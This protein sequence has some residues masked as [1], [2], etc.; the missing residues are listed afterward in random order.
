MKN[1]LLCCAALLLSALTQAQDY[2]ATENISLDTQ[3]T[4]ISKSTV[5]SGIIYERVITIAN[6]YNFNQVNTFN[7]ANY[8][9]FKQ[10]FSEMRRA[11]NDLKFIP[12]ATLKTMAAANKTDNKVDVAILNT[13][14]QILNYNE[15][16]PAA[17][18]LTFNTTTS[19]FVPI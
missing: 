11:S 16:N 13:P 2:P 12:L 8:S 3:L 19:R 17:G 1:S 6:L 5:T 10:A 18:G 15:D 4:N 9:Y 14:F 7:T